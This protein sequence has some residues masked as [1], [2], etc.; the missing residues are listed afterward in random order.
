M[1]EEYDLRGPEYATRAE[2]ADMVTKLLGITAGADLS[3]FPDM[4]PYHP[5]A[6]ALSRAVGLGLLN[7]I[8]GNLVPDANVTREQAFVILSRAFALPY[9]E[10]SVLDGFADGHTV[11]HWAQP[12]T[13]GLVASGLVQGSDGMLRPQDP[14]SRQELAQLLLNLTQRVCEGDGGTAI[15]PV[16]MPIPEQLQIEG[17]LYLCTE[18]DLTLKDVTVSGRL[19]LRGSGTVTLQNSGAGEIVLCDRVQLK[20]GKLSVGALKVTA[21]PSY[22]APWIGAELP[23]SGPNN[24]KQT[25]QVHWTLGNTTLTERSVELKGNASTRVYEALDYTQELPEGILRAT[26]TL[27]QDSL[28]VMRYVNVT[29]APPPVVIETIRVEA[30]VHQDTGLFADSM[31][32]QYIGWVNAGTTGIYTNYVSYKSSELQL[33]DGRSGWV[34]CLAVTISDANYIRQGDYSV[35]EKETYVNQS[36]YT[37]QTDYLV[38]I[39]LN[40]QRVNVFL[41]SAGNWKLAQ[42]FTVATGKNSTPTI[43]G[44]FEYFYRRDRWDFGD[45]YVEPVLIFNGGHAFHSRTYTPSGNLLD[46]TLGY[47]VSAGCIR[48][49]DE[50]IAWLDTYLPLHSTVVV[51]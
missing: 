6:E 36:G 8:D 51:Y 44:V 12:A 17:D 2:F 34:D 21:E 42:S 18:T 15:L 19:V 9:G 23:I 11:G 41:G 30:T 39:S 4:S 10:A 16:G 1:L 49:A 31:L 32:T 3:A 27:G 40:T 29:P 20:Q 26:V 33:S 35:E 5:Y 14:I 46:P 7:G 38:W 48:M 24:L 45:Y 22:E 13:A 37:S 43:A 50:D 47:P 25:A 28:T